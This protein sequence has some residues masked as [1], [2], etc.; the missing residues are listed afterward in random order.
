VSK[1]TCLKTLLF[2]RSVIRVFPFFST[3]IFSGKYLNKNITIAT[4]CYCALN[5]YKAVF[6]CERYEICAQYR[7]KPF[8]F[9]ICAEN[10]LPPYIV[11]NS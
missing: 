8:G 4:K 3:N 6:T 10:E 5:T 11:E 1:K 2:Q 7:K 9:H